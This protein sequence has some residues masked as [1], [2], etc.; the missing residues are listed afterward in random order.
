MYRL[1]RQTGF[2]RFA[3]PFLSRG[4]Q[5]I[6]ARLFVLPGAPVPRCRA[7]VSGLAAA[8]LSAVGCLGRALHLYQDWRHFLLFPYRPE[9][10]RPHL[11]EWGLPQLWACHSQQ[12]RPGL[13]LTAAVRSDRSLS[14]R[15]AAERAAV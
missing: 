13:L 9:T 3:F 8:R 2:G 14:R 11:V 6:S 7:Q 12:Y 15:M 4:A 10:C 5:K 1:P